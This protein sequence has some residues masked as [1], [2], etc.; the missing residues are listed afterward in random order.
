MPSTKQIRSKDMMNTR[1]NK[2]V[3][4][5]QESSLFTTQTMLIAIPIPLLASPLLSP[6]MPSS[7]VIQIPPVPQGQIFPYNDIT[8]SLSLTIPVLS[9][10]FIEHLLYTKHRTMPGTQK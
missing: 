6:G 8:S 3:P 4:I 10:I 7:L 1:I 9:I 2:H 5:R